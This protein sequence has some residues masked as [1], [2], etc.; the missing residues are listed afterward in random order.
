MIFLNAFY[1]SLY[2]IRQ[3]LLYFLISL[4]DTENKTL[5]FP[6]KPPTRSCL[7]W[8]VGFFFFPPFYRDLHVKRFSSMIA[9][10]K[11]TGETNAQGA[12]C[13][14]GAAGSENDPGAQGWEPRGSGT[15]PGHRGNQKKK[16][17]L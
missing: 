14:S 17:F 7:C 4:A 3:A 16:I 9:R 10:R 15:F 1:L 11:I 13:W 6:L 8:L 2:D 5:Y 12:E